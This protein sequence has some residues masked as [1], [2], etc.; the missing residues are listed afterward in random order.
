M[1]KNIKLLDNRDIININNKQ[2][3]INLFIIKSVKLDNSFTYG[4][5]E[6]KDTIININ[7]DF[8]FNYTADTIVDL[9]FPSD[10]YLINSLIN[11]NGKTFKNL[12]V[13]KIG[14]IYKSLFY[15][16]DKNTVIDN[17]NF[18]NFSGFLTENNQGSIINCSFENMNKKFPFTEN[19]YSFIINGN[20]DGIINNCSFRNIIFGSDRDNVIKDDD[21][22][23]ISVICSVNNG[24]INKCSFLN[25]KI[26]S[27][28]SAIICFTNKN[29]ISDCVIDG[30]N[31]IGSNYDGKL[32]ANMNGGIVSILNGG[33]LNNINIKGIIKA[34][35]ENYGLIC[36]SII[37]KSEI[38]CITINELNKIKLINTNA[39]NN[40]KNKIENIKKIKNIFIINNSKNETIDNVKLN[41]DKDKSTIKIEF[42]NGECNFKKKN[43]WAFYSIIIIFVF[44][45]LS[46][47]FI[48]ISHKTSS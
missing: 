31:N 43:N 5:V 48:P 41:N 20:N 30:I 45:I 33:V 47:L 28:K 8:E 9:N 14:Q 32:N 18:Y 10:I 25:I 2:D 27:N 13:K 4:D 11:G 34:T 44:I 21:Y 3:L 29:I 22:N 36:N 19:K 6:I 39:V 40:Y 15:S 26:K 35:G 7:I 42:V 16:I 12:N 46:L 23:G 17:L 37:N 38:S 24:T 1:N